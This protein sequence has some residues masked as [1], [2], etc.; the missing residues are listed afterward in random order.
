MASKDYLEL[1][2]QRAEEA[3]ERTMPPADSSP[4]ALHAAI[5]DAVFAGGDRIRPV[6]AL[7]ASEA[8]ATA[9][10]DPDAA[11]SAAV[12]IELLHAATRLHATAGDALALP[13]GDALQAMAFG[14]LAAPSA[15]SPARALRLSGIL[16]RAALA[17]A[18]TP[19]TGDLFAA[20]AELG[21]VAGGAPDDEVAALAA[22][23]AELG[24]ATRLAT[25]PD[26]HKL[27]AFHAREAAAHLME[28]PGTPASAAL[29]DLAE[30]IIGH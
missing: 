11:L 22:F 20:A 7:A 9:D 12:A 13:A 28:I 27:A 29:S 21:A 17:A 26:G 2:R 4:A 30:G 24:V 3:L 15:L 1:Q 19:E 25:E 16:A 5:R 23:G 10:G 6:L 14:A 18:L 8:A